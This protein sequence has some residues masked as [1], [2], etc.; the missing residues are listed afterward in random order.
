MITTAAVP[1]KPAPKLIDKKTVESIAPGSVIIDLGA[2]SGGNCEL[3]V[4]DNV[5]DH[6]GVMILGPTNLPSTMPKHASELYSR[7]LLNFLSPALTEEGLN[8]DWDDEIIK[9]SLLT[10]N[11]KIVNSI[12]DENKIGKDG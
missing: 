6:G 5:L 4:P 9:S 10:K 8:I 12:I 3:T 11:G 2:I 7:N 1:G